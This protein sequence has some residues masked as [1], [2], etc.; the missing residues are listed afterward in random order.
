[1]THAVAH[2]EHFESEVS[3][4]AGC[5]N[6][7]CDISQGEEEYQN[8]DGG[9]AIGPDSPIVYFLSSNSQDCE[10]KKICDQWRSDKV[11]RQI[12]TN[13]IARLVV[14]LWGI[15]ATGYY[16]TGCQS[17]W[18]CRVKP[19]GNVTWNMK[20]KKYHDIYVGG[21]SRKSWLVPVEVNMWDH[22]GFFAHSLVN[23]KIIRVIIDRQ[24]FIWLVS[25]L[26]AILYERGPLTPVGVRRIERKKF[27][28]WEKLQR[29]KTC[30]S[31][32]PAYRGRDAPL[33]FDCVCAAELHVLLEKNIRNV[34]EHKMSYIQTV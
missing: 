2:L 25:R 21:V 23:T 20:R 29:N 9:N 32:M 30:A 16:P 34:K 27:I 1:M 8:V 26:S 18:N 24:F 31:K 17:I 28:A 22:H 6:R 19:S 33:D 12:K 10:Q 7:D 14:P 5:I 13:E 4:E 11:E 3:N 15:V